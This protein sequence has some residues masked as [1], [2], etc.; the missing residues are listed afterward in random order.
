MNGMVKSAYGYSY[1][2]PWSVYRV[3]QSPGNYTGGNSGYIGGARTA[4]VTTTPTAS[5][6]SPV[7]SCGNAHPQPISHRTFAG[8]AIPPHG[9]RPPGPTRTPCWSLAP[10]QTSPPP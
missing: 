7:A 10:P 2:S 3:Y 6:P 5:V 8:G 1:C 9:P 4:P